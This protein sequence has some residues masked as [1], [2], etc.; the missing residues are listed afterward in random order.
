MIPASFDYARPGSLDEALGLLAQPGSKALAGGMSLL[1]LLK[2]RLAHVDRLVDI[3][4]LREL[5]GISTLGDGGLAIGALTSYAELLGSPEVMRYGLFIDALP[6]IGDVQVR[7]RGT[8][9]GAVAHADPSSDLP[10]CLLALD[11]SVVIR[12]PRGE[13]TVPLDGFYSGAF[14]SALEHDEL[15]VQVRLPAA[16]E[17]AGSAYV[18][19]EQPA[20]G[21]SLVGVA[22][23][24]FA[25]GGSRIATTGVGEVPYRARAVELALAGGA[26]ASEAAA[27]AT[28][29]QTVNGD[30]HANPEY[31]AA[32]A[33]VYTRRAIEAARARLG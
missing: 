29:G 27:H 23:V 26:S 14:A 20:S 8:V 6:G 10:A 32:M 4:R 25:G 12:S 5:R 33:A 21:Y 19:L 15:V 1:P 3:G 7:N 24:V 22:A 17:D 28:D 30:I 13:R 9:G 11:A 31:R 2:L 16:R 18:C